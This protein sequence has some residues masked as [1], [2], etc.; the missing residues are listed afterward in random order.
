MTQGPEQTDGAG[1]VLLDPPDN[2]VVP[3]HDCNFHCVEG[4]LSWAQRPAA[5]EV[6]ITK[7]GTLT[8]KVQ[9]SGIMHRHSSSKAYPSTKYVAKIAFR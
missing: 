6:V 7:L 4:N 3:V 8:E 1:Q 2:A 9:L 5:A